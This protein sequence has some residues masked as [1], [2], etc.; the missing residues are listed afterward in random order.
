M[1]RSF[2]EPYQSFSAESEALAQKNYDERQAEQEVCR[3]SFGPVTR[4]L[5]EFQKAIRFLWRLQQKV[6]SA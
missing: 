4:S 6:R 5:K 1:G 2:R 3:S